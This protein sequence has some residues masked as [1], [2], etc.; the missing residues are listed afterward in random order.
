[1]IRF[2]ELETRNVELESQLQEKVCELDTLRLE[3]T[4]QLQSLEDCLAVLKQTEST[5]NEKHSVE[6][7]E[8]RSAISAYQLQVSFFSF[9]KT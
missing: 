9:E 1:M 6:V 2:S 4:K 5:L 7:Q 8:L 3:N